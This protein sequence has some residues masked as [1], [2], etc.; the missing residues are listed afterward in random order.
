MRS[1][2]LIVGA[3][4]AAATYARMAADRGHQVS[5]IDKRKHIAGNC[6][7]YR[8]QESQVEVHKYG[9]HIFHT[10]S[11][12]VWQFVNRF[13]TFNNYVNRVKARSHG[14][15]Y[16]LPINLHTINQF[17]EK[18]FTPDQ[19]ASFIDEHRVKDTA[20]TLFLRVCAQ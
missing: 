1:H 7:T 2:F 3:G 16:S 20:P 8:D 4:L 6:F 12:K 18:D 9:P 10:N 5:V 14:Q 15:I 19:A 11:E 17:F 13:S